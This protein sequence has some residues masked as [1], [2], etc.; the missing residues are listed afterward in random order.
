[1]FTV[2]TAVVAEYGIA[3]FRLNGLKINRILNERHIIGC[4]NTDRRT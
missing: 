1:M 2:R 3:K 4:K